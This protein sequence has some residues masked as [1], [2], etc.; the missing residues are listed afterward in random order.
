L[1]G[2]QRK[3]LAGRRNLAVQGT[4]IVR[5]NLAAQATWLLRKLGCSGNLA[6]VEKLVGRG[7]LR[8]IQRELHGRG[9]SVGLS[10][11]IHII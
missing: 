1:I 2:S 5:A 7:D 4:L 10:V 11:K 8:D 3:E 6:A 9:N